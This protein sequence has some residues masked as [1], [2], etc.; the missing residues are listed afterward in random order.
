ME[1]AMRISTLLAIPVLALGLSAC[2][3]DTASENAGESQAPA[4]SVSIAP[5]EEIDTDR[6]PAAVAEDA[7]TAWISGNPADITTITSPDS[8]SM[9]DWDATN[10]TVE[11]AKYERAFG[12]CSIGDSIEPAKDLS[13]YPGEYYW[14]A[15]ECGGDE[16][17]TAMVSLDDENRV[18]AIGGN[19]EA[20]EKQDPKASESEPKGDDSGS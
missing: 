15:L 11:R 20:P 10:A 9:S 12:G 4:P 17:G 7:L 18:I 5:P 6:A 2:G 1:L 13:K 3:G 19:P 16:P 8:E 14:F